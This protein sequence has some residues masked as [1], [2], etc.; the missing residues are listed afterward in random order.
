[1]LGMPLP[2]TSSSIDGNNRK[3]NAVSGVAIDY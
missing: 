3:H 1:M 2:T